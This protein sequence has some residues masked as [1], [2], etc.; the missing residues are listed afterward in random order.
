MRTMTWGLTGALLVAFLVSSGFRS[1]VP[2]EPAAP[3]C[4]ASAADCG[5]DQVCVGTTPDPTNGAC[6]PRPAPG[7][8]YTADDCWSDAT[9]V[10]ARPCG[11]DVN[12]PPQLGDCTP[13]ATSQCCVR[14]ADCGDGL[15]CRGHMPGISRGVCTHRPPVG[16]CFGDADC[17]GGRCEDGFVCGCDIDCDDWGHVGSCAAAPGCRASDDCGVDDYCAF[18]GS[19]SCCLPNTDCDAEFPPC[20]GVCRRHPCESEE[21]LLCFCIEPDCDPNG[22]AVIRDGC[23]ICVDAATCAPSDELPAF[24]G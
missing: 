19:R 17:P 18:D 23:W 12:C 15:V 9:C 4:C 22:V 5:G 13:W 24:C 6:A 8:C 11:C 3:V 1:C 7:E 20:E 2:I 16:R 10:G 21:N 14:D